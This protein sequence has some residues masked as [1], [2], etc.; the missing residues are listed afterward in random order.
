[1]PALRLGLTVSLASIP[2]R[3]QELR[4]VVGSLLP[5]TDKVNVY[6]DGYKTVPRFLRH[7]KVEV[8]T[9]AEEPGLGDSGKFLWDITGR[10][11]PGVSLHCDDD[12]LYPKDYVRT[13]VR[14][15]LQ[16]HRACVGVHGSILKDGVTNYR[17]DRVTA[18]FLE[19]TGDMWCH[20]LGTGVLAHRVGVPALY[21]GDFP[22]A[23][24]AD[25]W[26]ALAAQRQEVPMLLIRHE[27]TWLQLLVDASR[28]S[29]WNRGQKL[30]CHA[31]TRAVQSHTAWR[32]HK[33]EPV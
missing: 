7:P 14:R 19:T 27:S 2:P 25:V 8:V 24:M 16:F 5:Q 26:F 33:S 4:S 23:N 32:I 11:S 29:I 6:L 3:Q 22:V 21:R 17:R 13:M 12:I 9:S 28:D 30:G 31:E 15:L 18:H 10:V 1:M 20:V